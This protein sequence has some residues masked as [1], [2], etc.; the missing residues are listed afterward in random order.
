MNAMDAI[1]FVAERKIEEAMAEG[2]FDNLPG[3]GK[4]LEFED[5]SH[6]PPDMRMAYT[7]LKNSGYLEQPADKGKPVSMRELMAHVADEGRVYGKMQRLKVM[8]LRVRKAR[9]EHCIE[10]ERK[11]EDEAP[12]AL[13]SPYLE[14]LVERV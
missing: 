3:M 6:L 10:P 13:S 9:V 2:Q 8:M 5:L 14:K 11:K 4:P 12:D 7:I 1:T